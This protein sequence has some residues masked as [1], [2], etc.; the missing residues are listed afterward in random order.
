MCAICDHTSPIV[1][2]SIGDGGTLSIGAGGVGSVQVPRRGSWWCLPLQPC[3]HRSRHMERA[4]SQ[5]HGPTMRQRHA[6]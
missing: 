1:D 5:N 3:E 4:V 6:R 2:R